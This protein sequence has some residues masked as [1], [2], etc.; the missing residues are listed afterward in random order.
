M[1]PTVLF[2]EMMVLATVSIIAIIINLLFIDAFIF[3]LFINICYL[4]LLLLVS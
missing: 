4:H 1:K 2:I 3:L